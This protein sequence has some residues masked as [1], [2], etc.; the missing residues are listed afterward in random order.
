M[1]LTSK[2]Y[3]TFKTQFLSLINSD[4]MSYFYH[5]TES[6]MDNIIFNEGLAMAEKE[7]YTTM[8]PI[9][10]EIKSDPIEFVIGESNRG[11][12]STSG[13]IILIGILTEDLQYAVRTNKSSTVK[14]TEE[15]NPEYILD[16]EYIIASIDIESFSINLNERFL[17]A[18]DIEYDEG[19]GFY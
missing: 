18:A 4:E 15:N 6:D 11:I 13:S 1:E 8:I 5:I 19:I 7:L 9:D 16:S 17:L 3:Q 2:D 10:E 14:W 12:N